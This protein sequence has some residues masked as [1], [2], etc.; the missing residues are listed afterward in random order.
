MT[1][2]IVNMTNMLANSGSSFSFMLLSIISRGK[3]LTL[4]IY[5]YTVF[6]YLADAF[7]LKCLEDTVSKA[8]EV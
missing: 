2:Y 6:S 3:Y 1:L 5:I 7:I 8:K 4:Y